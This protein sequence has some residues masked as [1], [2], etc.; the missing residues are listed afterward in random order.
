MCLCGD[1]IPPRE[2]TDEERAEWA[3]VVTDKDGEALGKLADE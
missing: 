3:R 1:P 2:I